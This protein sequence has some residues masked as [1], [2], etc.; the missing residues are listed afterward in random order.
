MTTQNRGS[1]AAVTRAGRLSA[2]HATHS[3]PTPSASPNHDKLFTKSATVL[4][5]S[6][7]FSHI[8]IRTSASSAGAAAK[9]FDVA[10]SKPIVVQPTAARPAPVHPVSRHSQG[11]GPAKPATR[12]WSG[13]LTAGSVAASSVRP[14]FQP[15]G[16]S[17]SGTSSSLSDITGGRVRRDGRTRP[18]ASSQYNGGG[19]AR[20]ASPERP[21]MRGRLKKGLALG[22]NAGVTNT[23]SGAGAASRN[24]RRH[25]PRRRGRVQ[26]PTPSRSCDPTAA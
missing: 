11:E 24:P 20:A 22:R 1:I 3:P 2:N 25:R 5:A 17:Q 9:A 15:T 12:R 4:A 18:T 21:S 19:P 23:G 13:R 7:R 10:H 14:T 8:L 6:G 26:P 16:P